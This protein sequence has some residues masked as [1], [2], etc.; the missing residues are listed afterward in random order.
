MTD[1]KKAI[2][3][4]KVTNLLA[5]SIELCYNITRILALPVNKIRSKVW[6]C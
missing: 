4:C 1:Y 5:N 6:G 3:R 2:L